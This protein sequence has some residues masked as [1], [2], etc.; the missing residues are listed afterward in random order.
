MRSI[1]GADEMMRTI[2]A[3]E[4]DWQSLSTPWVSAACPEEKLV[5]KAWAG[6]PSFG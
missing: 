3:K 6:P 4:R 1:P 2:R 5:C